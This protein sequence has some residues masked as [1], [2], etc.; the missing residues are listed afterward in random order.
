MTYLA[1]YVT[2]RDL[3]RGQT[4]T[5]TFEGQYVRAY[6]DAFRQQEQNTAKIMSLAFVVQKLVS[7]KPFLQKNATLTFLDLTGPTR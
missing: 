5:F 7:K 6:F 1:Q 3:D 4:L 2:S